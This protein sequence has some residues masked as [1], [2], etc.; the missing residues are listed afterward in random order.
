ML[1][2][3]IEYSPYSVEELKNLRKQI[4]DSGD[5]SLGSFSV[6]RLLVT[7]EHARKLF[8]E[9]WER[10]L[11]VLNRKQ[12]VEREYKAEI[13]DLKNEIAN[14]YKEERWRKY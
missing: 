5:V 3:N 2:N 7:A 9:E 12:R 14:A 11:D 10:V 1:I 8:E 4:E 6:S 13:A